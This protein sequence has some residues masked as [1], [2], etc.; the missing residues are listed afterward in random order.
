VEH[1]G[2]KYKEELMGVSGIGSKTYAELVDQ[3]TL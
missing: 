2:F 1:G 3:I